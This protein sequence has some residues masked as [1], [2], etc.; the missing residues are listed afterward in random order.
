MSSYFWNNFLRFFTEGYLEIWFG[1][2]LNI[3]AF[4]VS[5]TG[6]IV[7]TSVSV[8]TGILCV[9]FPFMSFIMLY[10]YRHAIR[11]GNE[12][13]LKRYGTMYADFKTNGAWY[14]FQYYP[15]FLVRR[16]IFVI[17]LVLLIEYPEIQCNSF[18]VYSIL[19]SNLRLNK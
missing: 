19:V 12:R 11:D 15:I 3:F 8:I 2:L 9:L 6:E 14:Q 13:L 10:E 1:A 4:T 18:I 7:S 5:D 16:F 17:G